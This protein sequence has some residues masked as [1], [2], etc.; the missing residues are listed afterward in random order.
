LRRRGHADGVAG[1]R[2][3]D[4]GGRHLASIP[5]RPGNIRGVRLR[6]YLRDHHQSLAEQLSTA[7]WTW[8]GPGTLTV[9][10]LLLAG[11]RFEVFDNLVSLGLTSIPGAVSACSADIACAL[12]DLNYSRLVISI[13][14]SGT[15]SL[16][17]GVSQ[18]APLSSGGQA[19]FQLSAPTSAVPE[20][21]SLTLLGTGL[22]VAYLRRRKRSGDNPA[23]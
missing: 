9:L 22:A 8:T 15:H 23:V 5:V 21:A 10:D 2:Q 3:P 16:T 18:N 17:I 20:P 11:D 13:I 1:T 19:V 7:P 4:Y 12:A 6:G 14:G